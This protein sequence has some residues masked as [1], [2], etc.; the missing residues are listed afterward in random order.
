MGWKLSPQELR[1]IE[2]TKREGEVFHEQHPDDEPK[3]TL[4]KNVVVWI[5]VLLFF[6]LIA[7]LMVYVGSSF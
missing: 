4:W 3:R 1:I 6:V 7:L 2:Q 5:A